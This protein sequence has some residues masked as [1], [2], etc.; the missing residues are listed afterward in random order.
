MYFLFS[1]FSGYE[2]N[3]KGIFVAFDLEQY[4]HQLKKNKFK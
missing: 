2:K 1:L 3:E 4:N